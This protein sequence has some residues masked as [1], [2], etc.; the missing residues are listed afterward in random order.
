MFEE[1]SQICIKTYLLIKIK[2]FIMFWSFFYFSVVCGLNVKCP[3]D[4]CDFDSCRTFR[5]IASLEDMGQ[6]LRLAFKFYILTHLLPD[7]SSLPAGLNATSHKL[8]PPATTSSLNSI[9]SPSSYF[10][11]DTGSQQ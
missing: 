11:P 10:W 5:N 6:S 1:M 8:L 7:L 9:L 2:L 4:S 3:I